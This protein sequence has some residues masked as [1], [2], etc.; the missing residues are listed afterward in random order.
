MLV[1]FLSDDNGILWVLN[2]IC[3]ICV[4]GSYTYFM[5]FYSKEYK[6]HVINKCPF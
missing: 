4:C 3:L 5:M 2:W 6:E 1:W